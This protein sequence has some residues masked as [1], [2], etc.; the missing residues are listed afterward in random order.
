MENPTLERIKLH[1][2]QTL[3]TSFGYCG[4]AEGDDMVM[5]NSSDSEGRDIKIEITISEVTP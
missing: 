1:A 2:I 4:V 3:Q 5:I